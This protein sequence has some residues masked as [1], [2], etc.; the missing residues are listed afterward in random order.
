MKLLNMRNLLQIIVKQMHIFPLQNIWINIRNYYSVEDIGH[1][2]YGR[3]VS[4]C[5][6]MSVI[7]QNTFSMKEEKICIAQIV[8]WSLIRM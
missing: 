8:K 2:R 3:L 5:Y 4:S 1:R 6:C 7:E